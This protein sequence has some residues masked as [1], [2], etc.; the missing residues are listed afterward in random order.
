MNLNGQVVLTRQITGPKNQLDVSTL[1]S[2]V[3]FVRLTNEKTV[4]VGKF[5]KQ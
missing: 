5:V 3:Y 1:P 2:G 4:K